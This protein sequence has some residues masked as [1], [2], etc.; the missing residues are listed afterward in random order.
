MTSERTYRLELQYD[1]TGLHGWAKQDGCPTVQG[2]IE[3]AFLK[4]L[5]HAPPLRV[6][7]RTDAGVHARRQVVSLHLPAGVD[8]RRLKASLNALTPPGIAVTRLVPVAAEFD[9]HKDAVSRT[10]RYF[11]RAGGVMSPFW[12]AYCWR[13]QGPLDV[14]AM[15]EAATLV[16]GRH[17]FT[18][19]TPTRTEHTYL[20]SRVL[21]SAWARSREGF[22]VFEIEADSFLRHMVRTLVGTMVEIGHGRRV[23]HQFEELLRGGRREDAGPTAPPHGLVLW[24]VKYGDDRSDHRGVGST[25]ALPR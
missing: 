15:R 19:F 14:A 24:N 13:V 8:R 2:N 22:L 25:H 1:G 3:Q 5:G 23:L 9:A 7:G 17:D 18:A 10:Y 16:E 11:L 21:R 12:T 20:R 6:A 4:V